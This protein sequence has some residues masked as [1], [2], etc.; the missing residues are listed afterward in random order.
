[1]NNTIAAT[2]TEP[3]VKV[4]VLMPVYNTKEEHL[5]KAMES[6]LAQTFTDFEFIIVNDASSDPRVEQ[7]VASYDDPRI[8]YYA[9][10]ENMGISLVRN[11]LIALSRGTYLAVMDHDDISLPDRF[12]KEVEY[13]D[14][15]PAVG[16]VGCQ[17]V[18]FQDG[19]SQSIFPVNDE[20]I[21]VA[22]MTECVIMHPT[23]MIRKSVLDKAGLGYETEFSP[24]EDYALYCQ[25]LPFT[26]FHNLDE[27]L[28]HYRWHEDNTCKRQNTKMVA[29]TTAIQEMTRRRHP[30]LVNKLHRFTRKVTRVRLFG[31]LPLMKTVDEN[32]VSR[33]FLFNRIPVFK[34]VR[35][36]LYNRHYLFAIIP[37]C[38]VKREAHVKKWIVEQ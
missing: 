14:A 38:T 18:W 12:K 17:F 22:M 4:S 3:T 15:N 20:D 35:S 1:M 25:L 24:A 27:V 7:V 33:S 13:L 10:A 28:F 23:C 9:N 34:T 32:G 5:R 8:R 6:I 11:K 29:A 30:E 21:R 26:K 2:A 31:F 37:L 16:V 36:E 19:N